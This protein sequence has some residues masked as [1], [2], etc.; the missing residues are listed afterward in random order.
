MINVIII[1]LLLLLLL[2]IYLNEY[3]NQDQIEYYTQK[4]Q[5]YKSLNCNHY[6]FKSDEEYEKRTIEYNKGG[7]M[8]DKLNHSM[9]NEWKIRANKQKN[10]KIH[11]LLNDLKDHMNRPLKKVELNNGI[12]NISV[13]CMFRF[14]DDYLD[15]F[16]HYYIMHGITQFYLYSNNNTDKTK[17][18]LQPYIDKGY[19]TLIEWNNE[20]LLK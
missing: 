16:L 6:K 8:K 2:F 1:L 12:H 11:Y 10:T 3:C 20:K 9:N 15:E 13:V 17:Q 14:E 4:K 18:I 19:I 5:D 7:Q